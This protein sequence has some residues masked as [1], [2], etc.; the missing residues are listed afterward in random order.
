[1]L[2]YGVSSGDNLL[3]GLLVPSRSL[4]AQQVQV[5]KPYRRAYCLP[6]WTPVQ[7]LTLALEEGGPGAPSLRDRCELL[8]MQ[9]YLQS[10]WSR[11]AA[12]ASAVHYL[13]S[14]PPIRG[15]EHE[16]IAL[17]SALRERGVIPTALPSGVAHTGALEFGSLAAL[18]GVRSVVISYDG[19]YVAGVT[20][21]AM[22][23]W[24]D[25]LGFFY[26]CGRALRTAGSGATVAEWM[27]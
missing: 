25:S 11:N 5:H 19:G 23:M 6:K 20:A 22:V 14:T 4:V 10:S 3:R 18:D 2:A 15:W 13:V 21:W 7:F 24:H 17:Q 12:A 1:M 16:G 9:S 26:G 27:G 8:L